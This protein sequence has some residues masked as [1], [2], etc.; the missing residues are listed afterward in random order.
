[1]SSIA[2][3]EQLKFYY[4]LMY[5]TDSSPTLGTTSENLDSFFYNVTN[6]KG[7]LQGH[8]ILEDTTVYQ[9]GSWISYELPFWVKFK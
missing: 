6:Q 8:D 2:I 1:M 3:H 5:F 9:L 4:W 7:F